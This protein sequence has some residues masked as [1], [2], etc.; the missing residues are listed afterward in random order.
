[1]WQRKAPSTKWSIKW[2]LRTSWMQLVEAIFSKC[3][4]IFVELLQ[5][6]SPSA[7]NVIADLTTVWTSLD[8][9]S[10]FEAGHT[11]PNSY[12]VRK[13]NKSY[14]SGRNVMFK[15]AIRS[16]PT[17]SQLYSKKWLLANWKKS[18]PHSSSCSQVTNSAGHLYRD[19]PKAS[20]GSLSCMVQLSW[21]Q[22]QLL[23]C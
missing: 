9:Y 20:P 7:R 19:P 15:E 17:L 5:K 6:S 16:V 4:P 2:F 23:L 22:Q 21:S 13:F 18:T 11:V 1:M 3:N 10:D 8:C 12:R 14:M